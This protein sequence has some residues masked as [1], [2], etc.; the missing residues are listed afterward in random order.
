VILLASKE[1]EEVKKRTKAKL[2]ANQNVYESAI[3][4]NRSAIASSTSQ[5]TNWE[6]RLKELEEIRHDL[7]RKTVPDRISSANR[8]SKNANSAYIESI[9]CSQYVAADIGLHFATKEVHD[10]ASLENAL[11]EIGLEMNRIK[12]AIKTLEDNINKMNGL[13]N[14]LKLTIKRTDN[15]IANL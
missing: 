5:K 14:D 11:K 12:E 8:I 1:D 15:I 7:E 3:S 10:G 2:V 4:S 9:K 13:I 6:K